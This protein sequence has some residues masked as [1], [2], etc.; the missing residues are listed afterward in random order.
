MHNLLFLKMF[1]H[2][3]KLF[4]WYAWLFLI[5]FSPASTKLAGTAWVLLIVWAFWLRAT[6]PRRT[7]QSHYT[8]ALERASSLI[9]LCC[10]TAFVSRTIGQLYWGDGWNYRHFDIRMLLTGVALYIVIRYAPNLLSRRNELLVALSL[11][12]ISA[13]L[14]AYFYRTHGPTNQIPWAYGMALFAV[15]L[16]AASVNKTLPLNLK[17]LSILGATLFC[18]A[19]LIVGVRG[20]FFAVLWVGGTILYVLFRNFSFKTLF[21]IR[22][23]LAIIGVLATVFVLVQTLPQV[24]HT[25]KQRVL[26]ALSEIHSFQDAK[27]N[28]SVGLR[29]HFLDKGTETLSQFPLMGVGVQQRFKLL[30]GWSKEVNYSNEG[31][32]H[33][34]NEYLNSLLDYGVFGGI[35]TIAYLIAMGFAA[36]KLRKFNAP[37]AIGL[38]GCCFATATTFLTNTDTLHNYSSVT[39]GL[40]LLFILFLF[41]IPHH[42]ECIK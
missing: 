28:T 32:F 20:A 42:R 11:A 17:W 30:L 40:A 34:H 24:L 25:P 15:V 35:A 7:E 14:T 26:Q 9:L 38:A 1:I 33:A 31:N 16:S 18:A 22:N 19:I 12:S 10:V 27:K 4:V 41:P 2:Q 13:V 6:H 21:N 3:K 37:M 5:I 29:L 8:L 36:F 39:L 23:A